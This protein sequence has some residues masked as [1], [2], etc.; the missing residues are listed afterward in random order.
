MG[1]GLRTWEPVANADYE[2]LKNSFITEYSFIC[3]CMKVGDIVVGKP[4]V[5][6]SI[7]HFAN[8]RLSL[9]QK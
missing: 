9:D 7:L 4:T 2:Y 5:L 3:S 6:L 8:W 1:I